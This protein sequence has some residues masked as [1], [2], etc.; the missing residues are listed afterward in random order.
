VT[1]ADL[2]A[3]L[4]RLLQRID[5][6][7]DVMVERYRA[8]IVDYATADAAQLDDVRTVSVDNARS[9]LVNLQRGT[10]P[11]PDEFQ[12]SATAAARRVH[13]GIPL[14]AFLHAFR[15]WTQILWQQVLE[16]A[17]T[18]R[19]GEREAALQIAGQL[20]THVDRVSSAGALAYLE[21][22]QGIWSDRE[23]LRRDLLELLLA[24]GDPEAARRHA[25]SLA[26][27]L[28]DDYAVVVVRARER[29]ADDLMPATLHARTVLRGVVDAARNAL[30]RAGA[31]ALVGVRHG[32]VVA[33]SP[34][35]DRDEHAQVRQGCEALARSVARDGFAVGLGGWHPGLAHVA[36]SFSES[37]EAA[38]ASARAAP[39]TAIAFDD[40]VI[41]HLLR[42]SADADRVLGEVLAPVAAYD[43]DR[44]AGLL[45]TL[46]TYI[47]SGF[48]PT[49]SAQELMVHPN[50]VLYRL[51]R[52]RELTGRDPHEPD[53]LV[54]LALALKHLD[55]P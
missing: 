4:E 30:A 7:G 14:D 55:E 29:P 47:S 15:L 41:S 18:D 5:A 25:A 48:S 38:L 21:E 6:I 11:G 40:I 16:E 49:R 31:P 46:R 36:Q 28:A 42:T 39:G 33:L 43:A 12:H 17:R 8:E 2:A 27:R 3:V 26:I 50:T 34:A 10:V 13:Q 9:V 44:E 1:N 37:R 51:K 22:V 32:E 24:G 20:M 54:L 45:A 23:V 35:A 52:I 19:P 53:D